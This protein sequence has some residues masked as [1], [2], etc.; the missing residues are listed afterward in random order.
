M[1]IKHLLVS[2]FVASS[3]SALA[4]QVKVTMNAVSKTMTL[5]SADNSTVVET[6]DPESGIY[7]FEAP[8]GRYILTGYDTDGATINGT[9]ALEIPESNELQEFTILTHTA[10]VTNKHEDGSFW[11]IEKGDFTFEYKVIGRDGNTIETTLGKSVTANRYTFLSFSGNTYEAWFIP[12]EEHKKESY[13]SLYKSNT[14]IYNN[15]LS[16]AIPVSQ[17]YSIS[18]PAKAELFIGIKQAHFVDFTPVEPESIELNGDSKVYTYILADG[19]QYNYRTGMNGGLTQAGYFTMSIDDAKRPLI[20]FTEAD[21]QSMDPKQVNHDVNSNSGYETGDIFLNINE[22]GHLKMNIGETFNFHAMRTWEI[23]S[24]TTGNYFMEPDF[25]YTVLDIDGK[26]SSGVVEV[27]AQEGSAW[28]DV[29]AI[30][31]GTAIVLVTYDAMRVNYYNNAERKAFEGGEY[32]GA[33]WPE[34]TGVYVVTVGEA[35][36]I[37]PNMIINEKINEGKAK[38]AGK[39]VDAEHDVFYYLDT[40]EGAYYTFTPQGV[41]N[42]TIAYPSIGENMSTYSGF[43]TQGVTKNEDGSYSLLLKEGRQIVKLTDANGKSVY[44]VLTAKACHR[45]IINVDRPD[46]KKFQP[47]DKVK[48]QYSG[49]RHPSNK[50]AGVYNMSAYVTYNGVP[51]GTSVILGSN[52][53]K[54]GSSPAAQA[55]TLTI[56]ED[57]DV[58]ATPEILFTEG[59]VEAGGFGDPYGSHRTIDRNSGRQPNFTAVGQQAYFGYVPDVKIPVSQVSQYRIEVKSNVPDAVITVSFLGNELTPEADGSYIGKLGIY[60]IEAYKKGYRCLHQ[61]FTVDDDAD[62]N[63]VFEISLVEAPDAWDGSTLSE[64]SVE[65]GVYQITTG[66]ELAWVADYVNSGNAEAKIA[67]VNDIDL[68][69]YTWTPMGTSQSVPFSGYFNGNGHHVNGLYINAPKKTLL[70]LIGY[71]KG[72][73]VNGVYVHGTIVGSGSIGGIVGR[74]MADNVIDCCGNYVDVTGS[75]DNVGG[76]VGHVFQN[77]NVVTNC[78]NAG[79]IT[80]VSNCGGVVGRTQLTAIVIENIFNVGKVS[81]NSV[82]ALVGGTGAKSKMNNAFATEELNVILGQTTVSEAQMESGEV[83]Y[84]LGEV[85]GQEIGVDPYPVIGGMKVYYDEPTNT[86]YNDT[87]GAGVDDVINN[88]NAGEI[89]YC[90]LQGVRSTRPFKGLNIIMMPDGSVKKIYVK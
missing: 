76:V 53:Y 64:P 39:Y 34:N 49:L 81:G 63:V 1:K 47:G 16:G 18:V 28:A 50:L 60:N 37:E 61:S 48:I 82:A 75:T 20:G 70:G 15:I 14:S 19:Q 69:D 77:T 12:S 26:A 40:E 2:L 58:E 62:E 41:D 8:A 73:N 23:T 44:Q 46:S 57:Y 55:V 54:F 79:T 86:Y 42:V 67:L 89:I 32:W 10:Y 51:N 9:I 17:S 5:A 45:D 83:A 7:N 72:S 88:V 65:D 24:S 59:V 36:G 22:R 35:T 56:P 74:A 4:T 27:N 52:Q 31:N 66:S 11:T 68:G 21:Y 29:K 90:N 6:S 78:F 85:F 13:T 30:G 25:H 84:R 71:A 80:G 43:Q 3:I 38:M 33:I 87:E